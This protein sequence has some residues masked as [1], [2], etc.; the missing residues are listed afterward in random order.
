LTRIAIEPVSPALVKREQTSSV[1]TKKRTK[2]TSDVPFL[3]Q[4]PEC[5]YSTNSKEH[6]ESHKKVHAPERLFMCELCPQSFKWSHSL[7]RHVQS[8]HADRSKYRFR[9]PREGC[10]KAFSRKD[11]LTNH[12]ASHDGDRR[13]P[14]FA[15]AECGQ[16]FR[17]KKTL[18]GHLKTHLRG[19]RQVLHAQGEPAQ[20]RDGRAQGL[21]V[22]VRA[23]PRQGL[24]TQ[25]VAR[26][27]R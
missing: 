1:P 8:T 9:C 14:A 16:A 6:L 19:L 20:A 27:P 13:T 24:P 5:T 4:H 11:H 26:R 10:G 23:L 17:A 18:A 12:E 21:R 2:R 3:C 7:R 15:C 25:V 22:R